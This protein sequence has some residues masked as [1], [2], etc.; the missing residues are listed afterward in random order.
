M[1]LLERAAGISHVYPVHN[2]GN[3]ERCAAI[4]QGFPVSRAGLRPDRPILQVRSQF[5]FEQTTI[6][7]I[8]SIVPGVELCVDG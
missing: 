8:L 2:H 1:L 6:P 7:R 3:R 5:R 4:A